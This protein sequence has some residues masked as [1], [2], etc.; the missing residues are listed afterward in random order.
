M[1]DRLDS[2]RIQK[3]FPIHVSNVML[4]DPETK[5]NIYS[6]RS[7]TRDGFLEDGTKV[8]IAKKSGAMIPKPVF[9][10]LSYKE[11]H[12]NI[13]KYYLEDGPKDTPSDIG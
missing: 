5:Y 11:R 13:S 2:G 3:E 8:R 10:E 1:R 9:P 7:R 12:K 6:K 4:I